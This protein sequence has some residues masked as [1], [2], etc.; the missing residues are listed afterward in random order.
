MGEPKK[1]HEEYLAISR[2][3]GKHLAAEMSAF[4]PFARAANLAMHFM[5]DV[6]RCPLCLDTIAKAN[7]GSQEGKATNG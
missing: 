6:P 4:D 7:E 2:V 5:L 3:L 1:T